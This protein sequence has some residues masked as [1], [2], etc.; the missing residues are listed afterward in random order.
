M[1]VYLTFGQVY[2]NI[3][4]KILWHSILMT[5]S[6]LF[7]TFSHSV[8]RQAIGFTGKCHVFC[9][10][11]ALKWNGNERQLHVCLFAR[12]RK[13]LVISPP[14]IGLSSPLPLRIYPAPF[15]LYWNEFAFLYFEPHKNHQ[16]IWSVLLCSLLWNIFFCPAISP[17]PHLT[18]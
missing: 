12:Y 17:C 2:A 7:K 16:S 18:L 3:R 11:W 10:Q 4:L 8:H 14:F 6:H 13:L 5:L 1:H 15:S 9:W